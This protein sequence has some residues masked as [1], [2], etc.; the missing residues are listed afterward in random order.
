MKRGHL[1]KDL[2]TKEILFNL[3][4]FTFFYDN[5]NSFSIFLQKFPFTNETMFKINKFQNFTPIIGHLKCGLVYD[6]NTTA[7][8]NFLLVLHIFS[9]LY[10]LN[11]LKSVELSCVTHFS[12]ITY[13][14]FEIQ[15][16]EMW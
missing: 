16:G 14:T 8:T 1:V 6:Q 9:K 5:I 3:F 4:I 13:F 12:S 10:N 7:S 15:Y 11:M 2:R